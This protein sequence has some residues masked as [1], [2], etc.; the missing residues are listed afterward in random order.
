MEKMEDEKEVIICF[1]VNYIIKW[2]T[3]YKTKKI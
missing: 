1:M 3:E 2:I